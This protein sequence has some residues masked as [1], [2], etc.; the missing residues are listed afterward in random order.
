[1]LSFPCQQDLGEHLDLCSSGTTIVLSRR[2]DHRAITLNAHQV[3]HL[4]DQLTEWLENE[5]KTDTLF[6]GEL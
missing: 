2:K 6:T 4:R 3:R 5:A 1:M